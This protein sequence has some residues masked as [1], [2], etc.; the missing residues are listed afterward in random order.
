VR[1]GKLGFQDISLYIINSNA[2]RLHVKRYLKPVDQRDVL[3][4]LRIVYPLVEGEPAPNPTMSNLPE[5]MKSL[6]DGREMWRVEWFYEGRYSAMSS[7]E[8][9][10][11]FK[12]EE[13]RGF[14]VFTRIKD[15]VGFSKWDS[16]LRLWFE[17]LYRPDQLV[18]YEGKTIYGDHQKLRMISH[19]HDHDHVLTMSVVTEL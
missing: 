16:A 13:L 3:E 10:E 9:D 17:S 4:R 1:R 6:M 19:I 11:K 2:V 12:L 14:N 8:Y 18:F 15:T 5:N 7:E